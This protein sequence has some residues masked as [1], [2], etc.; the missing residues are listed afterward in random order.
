MD[1]LTRL[2]FDLEHDGGI[3]MRTLRLIAQQVG[4]EVDF[5]S[6]EIGLTVDIRVPAAI[7]V[8]PQAQFA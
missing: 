1:T 5:L 3:G 2:G 7:P 4:V 6:G 8:M